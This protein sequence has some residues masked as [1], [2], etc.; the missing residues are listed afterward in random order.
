MLP[1]CQCFLQ[2]RT[3]L[4]LIP[5]WPYQLEN[6]IS[7]IVVWALG[8]VTDVSDVLAHSSLYLIVFNPSSRDSPGGQHGSVGLLHRLTPYYRAQSAQCAETGGAAPPQPVPE[9][10]GQPKPY[11]RTGPYRISRRSG[12]TPPSPATQPTH[13]RPCC[14]PCGGRGRGCRQGCG[15]REVRGRRGWC[16]RCGRWHQDHV[17]GQA[18]AC[19][20][21][22]ARFLLMLRRGLSENSNL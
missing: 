19:L 2:L 13:P 7:A 17:G 16:G 12:P 4:L 3:I 11:Q 21:G 10:P 20:K 9:Q 14:G 18:G 15:G 8:L 5:S 1:S 6:I 22:S